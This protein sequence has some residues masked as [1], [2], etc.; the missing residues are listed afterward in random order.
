MIRLLIFS[1]L[2]CTPCFA[3]AIRGSVTTKGTCTVGNTGDQNTFVINCGIGKQQGEKMLEIVN[4]I[5]ANQLEPNAVM[6]KLDELLTDTKTIKEGMY[7]I[8]KK[9]RGRHLDARQIESLAAVVPSK[10]P[11]LTHDD[12]SDLIECEA[13]PEAVTLGDDIAA[14]FVRAGWVSLPRTSEGP[15]EPVPRGVFVYANSK[16]DSTTP[17]LSKLIILLNDF[18]IRSYPGIDPSVPSGRF[19][20]IV[21]SQP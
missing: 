3:Q 15:L 19:K 6:S 17:W 16:Y 11:W 7:E 14:I 21:G 5:L 4:K 9:Q 1:L 18:G 10:P 12:L 13:D 2:A 8:Q 20:I